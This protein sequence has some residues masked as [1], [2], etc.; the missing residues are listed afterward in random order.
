MKFY[1][2]LLVVSAIFIAVTRARSSGRDEP[3]QE[4]QTRNLDV[5]DQ[6]VNDQYQKRQSAYYS[7]GSEQEYHDMYGDVQVAKNITDCVRKIAKKGIIRA[8]PKCKAYMK[9]VAEFCRSPNGSKTHAKECRKV[10][11][12]IG[13]GL[14][15]DVLKRRTRKPYVAEF[16]KTLASPKKPSKDNCEPTQLLGEIIGGTSTL[17][18]F[19][20]PLNK[21]SKTEVLP[22][23]MYKPIGMYEPFPLKK[24]TSL[25]SLT[26][27]TQV[28]GHDPTAYAQN[29]VEKVIII[30]LPI[31]QGD[32]TVIYC[33]TTPGQFHAILFDC[34]ARGGTFLP[35]EYFQSHLTDATSITV[36]ISHGHADHYNRIPKVFD[37]T[38]P[39]GMQLISK[40]REV[41]VGGPDTDYSATT[42][43]RWLRYIENHER[44]PVH[45]IHGDKYHKLPDQLLPRLCSDPDIVFEIVT[46]TGPQ[47]AKKKNERG[48]VMRLSCEACGAQLLL[49]GDME[50]DSADEMVTHNRA[51]LEATHYKMAHHGAS[52]DD[53][54]RPNKGANKANWLQSIS[55]V[56]VHV[57]HRHNG[58]YKHPC[59]APFYRIWSLGDTLGATAPIGSHGHPFDCFDTEG[60][61]V[62]Y[63]NIYHRVYST[64][65]TKDVLCVIT[66]T[67]ASDPNEEERA[68]TEYF[69]GGKEEFDPSGVE[70]PFP[71]DPGEEEED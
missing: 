32:C 50:D 47:D 25:H 43:S 45:Y 71:H 38:T 54:N 67:F 42:I 9:Q 21:R 64:A 39:I 11:K 52:T 58:G 65:P 31:G 23:R 41:I 4:L 44:K 30:T 55:P 49:A 66:L 61:L 18:C 69:C 24:F 70:Y 20:A 34:G 53:P 1:L 12:S 26:N 36:M 60:N 17:L 27:S 33:P 2:G 7:D 51:V 28:Q 37:T 62:H 14:I 6:P 63:T 29:R 35:T 22:L 15:C 8:F 59:C 40:I 3:V 48:M 10:T 16:C 5:V 56:E 68:K 19:D 46:R 13:I 57:S